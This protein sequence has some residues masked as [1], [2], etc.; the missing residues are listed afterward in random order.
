MFIFVGTMSDVWI[1]WDCSEPSE[2]SYKQ[3]RQLAEQVSLSS[4]W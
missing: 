2:P 1:C 3:T 4:N